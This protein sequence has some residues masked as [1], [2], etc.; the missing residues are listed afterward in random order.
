MRKLLRHLL[1]LF[2]CFCMLPLT[3]ALAAENQEDAAKEFSK[4]KYITGYSGFDSCKFFFDDIVL[5]GKKSSGNADFTVENQDGIGY[6]Y[7]LF[8]ERYGEYTV[9]DN[10]SGETVTVGK[11]SILHDCLDMQALFGHVP[12]SVTVTFPNG[13]VYINEVSLFSPGNLPDS[14]QQWKD[15]AYGE[16][17]LILFSTHGDDE[18]LFFAGILPY[19]AGELGYQV[20]VVYLTDHTCDSPFRVH[21]MLN[22]LWAV[23]VTAYPVFGEYDDFR[24]DTLEESY[25]EFENRGWPKEQMLGFVVEQLRAF[26]PLVVATHDFAGE[27]GHGQHMVYADLVAEALAISNDPAQF[28][29]LAEAYGTCEVQKGYFHLYEENQIVMDWDKPLDNFGGMTAYEVTRDLGYPCHE[30]QY[31]DFA[32][33]FRGF[34]TAAEVVKYNPCYYGLY[35]TTVGTDENKNDFFEHVTTHA[36]LKKLAEEEEAQR[37]QAEAEQKAAAEAS[38]AAEESR[39]AEEAQRLAEEA[40]RREAE[41]AR[42]AARDKAETMQ[43][44]M[45]LLMGGLVVLAFILL[46]ILFC[47]LRKP[48]RRRKRPRGGKFSR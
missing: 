29:E 48:K 45:I 24:R 8:F 39:A 4:T 30:S 10:D 23:G 1:C 42:Q 41:A 26:K 13:S 3:P 15:P 2:L 18:Q 11:Y 47:L 32:W 34:D 27:Y 14:V 36:E 28:P 19:Y 20:Q 31:Q 22:G 16:A 44:K 5:Y 6:I 21:E 9:T 7:I 38:W 43:Q 46:T 35:W 17:D 33:Y 40:A 12:T 25:Q 37:Q